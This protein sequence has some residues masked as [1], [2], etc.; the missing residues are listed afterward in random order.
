MG[1]ALNIRNDYIRYANCWEDADILLEALAV[2]SESNVLSIGSAGDNSFS[3][4]TKNP[5]QVVAV[6]INTTQLMLIALKKAAFKTLEYLD[7]LG[8]LGVASSSKR[9]DLTKK[10]F[11]ALTQ[12][13]RDYWRSNQKLIETGIIH[14]GKFERYFQLFHGYVMPLIHGKKR[15]TEL[16]TPKST[17]EQHQFYS[18]KWNTTR[19]RMLFKLFFSKPV[20]GR[21]GRDPAFLKQVN[22]SVGQHIFNMAENHLSG[23]NC[24]SNYLLRYI[25]TGEFGAFLPHYLREENHEAI[26]R[27][28]N[29]LVLYKGYA[30]EAFAEFGSFNRFNLSDIFEYMDETTF[31]AVG[32]ALAENCPS[33]SRL[34]YWNLMVDRNLGKA[35]PELFE[36]NAQLSAELTMRDNGF[37]YN[38]FYLD[39]RL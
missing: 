31:K 36:T 4:L 9:S 17:E 14:Q 2:N 5:G 13:E 33:D 7:L 10:V 37:F 27:N 39:K 20:M 22:V 34:A 18:A 25:F 1:D 35:L 6:D 38:A 24:Q 28:L 32:S 19:W 26:T 11:E 21:A 30:Q 15:I 29:N 12:E 23:T 3:L 16:L 8:F